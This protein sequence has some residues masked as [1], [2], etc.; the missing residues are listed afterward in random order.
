MAGALNTQLEKQGSY[1]LG[2]DHGISS[3]DIP[4]ALRVMTLTSG[5]FGLIVILP[6]LALRIFIFAL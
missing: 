3:D 5:M 6:I 2:D 4:R 1:T